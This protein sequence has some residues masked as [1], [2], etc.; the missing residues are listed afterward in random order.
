VSST[1]VDAGVPVWLHCAAGY[2]AAIAASMLA[3]VGRSP[4]LVDDLFDN[5]ARAGLLVVQDERGPAIGT[6]DLK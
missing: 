5:A 2:R 6:R 4:V 3:A 1:G